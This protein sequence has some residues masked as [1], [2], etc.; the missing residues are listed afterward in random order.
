GVAEWLRRAVRKFNLVAAE[1]SDT[2]NIARWHAASVAGA[3]MVAAL[4]YAPSPPQRF[5]AEFDGKSYP[6]AAIETLRR[7]PSARIFTDDQWGDYLIYRLYPLTKVFVD[8]RSDFYGGDFEE[9]YI[10]VLNVKY[11]WEKTLGRFGVD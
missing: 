5:R 1:T 6:A 10:D 7:D 3:L 2:D 11:D 4:L 9:K 8:G